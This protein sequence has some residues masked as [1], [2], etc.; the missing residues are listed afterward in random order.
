MTWRKSKI[1]KQALR[2]KPGTRPRSRLKEGHPWGSL[3][4]IDG[5]LGNECFP[6]VSLTEECD[7]PVIKM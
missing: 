6:D 7:G 1:L 3:L 4:R 5:V 2:G